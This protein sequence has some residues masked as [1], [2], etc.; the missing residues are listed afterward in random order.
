MGNE[1]ENRNRILKMCKFRIW[2]RLIITSTIL[3]R[4]SPNFACCREM[5]SLQCLLFVR[6]TGSSLPILEMC[7]FRFW[8]YSGSDDHVFQQIST[9]SHLQIKFSKADFVFN[10]EWNRKQETDFRGVQ[11]PD[12]VSISHNLNPHVHNSLP[13]SRNFASGLG[14]WAQHGRLFVKETGCSLLILEVCGFRFRQFS[15]SGEHICWQISTKSRV[16]IKFSNADFAFNVN[17]SENRNQIL[18]MCKCR[19]LLV[20]WI[21]PSSIEHNCACSSYINC[22]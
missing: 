4:F 18:E 21:D 16:Q 2:L 8:Q 1:T 6:Q 10:G 19:F 13:I 3:Y 17:E 20:H 11:I 14:M 5:L 7:G 12:L 9:K 22:T 15:G